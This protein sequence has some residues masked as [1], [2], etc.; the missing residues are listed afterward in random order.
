MNLI[1]VAPK[2]DLSGLMDI[3]VKAGQPIRL[4]VN[5]EGEP[6]PTV[7]WRINDVSF[8]GNDHAELVVKDNRTEINIISSVRG[9]TGSYEITAE[10]EF[11]KDSGK[12]NV[13]VLDVPGTPEGPLQPS[14]IHKEGCTLNWKP[15]VDDGGS[16]ITH[17]VVEKMDASRGTWQEVGTSPD[18][19]MKVTK[20]TPN[21][22][23][24]FRVKAVNMLG[25]S[26]PLETDKEITAKNM[27]G[28]Y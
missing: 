14:N 25:E 22:Q 18:C 27:F 23:Y 15:P 28:K 2:L 8:N 5:F 20:L 1:T 3:R 10:N 21:K 24:M 16:P 19:Q 13:T 9:D 17:Y 12:C 4:E 7:S 6:A 26:K 11:G